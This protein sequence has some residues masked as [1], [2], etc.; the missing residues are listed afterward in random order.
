MKCR[1]SFC[2]ICGIFSLLLFS[3]GVSNKSIK[4]NQEL[5]ENVSNPTSIEELKEAIG[6][7]QQKVAEIQQANSQIGIWYKILGTRYVD[8][9]MYGEALKCFQEALKYYPDNQNLYYY[10]GVCAGYMSHASMDFDAQGYSEMRYNYLKLSEDAFLRAI[11]IEE[12]YVRAL[13]GIGVLYVYELDE[14][15]KAIPYL[16]KILTIDTKNVDAM[17]V[18]AKAYYDA[19]EFD[20]SAKIYDKIINTTKSEQKKANAAEGKKIALDALY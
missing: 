1:I 16:E 4:W 15:N 20:K 13:Y 18:L 12:R 8:Q 7:Y 5:E 17:F 14:S 6:K 2:F 19:Q 10:V 11:Q 3:C 9:K